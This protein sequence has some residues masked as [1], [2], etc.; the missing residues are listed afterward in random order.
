[1]E[2]ILRWKLYLSQNKQIVLRH[3]PKNFLCHIDS[4]SRLELPKYSSEICLSSADWISKLKKLAF[5]IDGSDIE[6]GILTLTDSEN[7]A[8]VI[9]TY[10]NKNPDND[11]ENKAIV[12]D[13]YLNKNPD[14]DS[15][16]K[17][18]VIDTYLNKNPDN[19]T[20]SD[21]YTNN[22]TANDTPLKNKEKAILN[23]TYLNN[24]VILN[25][26]YL[27]NEQKN[28][29]QHMYFDEQ[30][31]MTQEEL[32]DFEKAQYIMELTAPKLHSIELL[33]NYY[34]K[35]H[36]QDKQQG[37]Q[38]HTDTDI[39]YEQQES[40]N[41]LNFIKNN[42]GN[43]EPENNFP[44]KLEQF[45][46]KKL[47]KNELPF[48]NIP[49]SITHNELIEAQMS[50]QI[51]KLYYDYLKHNIL[52]N[53]K[54]I[55]YSIQFACENLDIINDIIMKI[56]QNHKTK[57]FRKQILVPKKLQPLVI[58][59]YHSQITASGGHLDFEH[60]LGTLY[61]SYYFKGAYSMMLSHVR[62]CKKCNLKKLAPSQFNT[63]YG[64][65]RIP[66][67]VGDA[68]VL[69]HIGPLIESNGYKY[70]LLVIEELSWYCIVFPCYTT[71]ALETSEHLVDLFLKY[72]GFPNVIY[73]DNATAFRN[74]IIEC[75]SKCLNIDIHYGIAFN[76]QSQSIAERFVQT[77]KK[78]ISFHCEKY[79]M[80]SNSL[81]FVQYCI[82]TTCCTKGQY[83]S[84]TLFHGRFARPLLCLDPENASS[85]MPINITQWPGLFFKRL[86]MSYNIARQFLLDKREKRITRHQM[87]EKIP[88]LQTGSIVYLNQRKIKENPPKGEQASRALRKEN[89]AGPFLILELQDH[90]AT[91]LDIYRLKA[92]PKNTA[93]KD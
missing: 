69:D 63:T 7:K 30:T 52:P 49:R 79:S 70:V 35:Y 15:E 77:V 74:S 61:N 82:N 8:I 57:T 39:N 42:L 85:H 64:Q 90:Q 33:N 59:F 11:S 78:L 31:N 50:D 73:M 81:S 45:V 44:E 76:P 21:I 87:K 29:V 86:I 16:N 26:T 14:N 92:L 89:N 93:E 88:S 51:L 27:N 43:I 4:L 28:I 65:K 40:I 58:E 24:E 56:T 55:A 66:T 6:D 41:T 47:L 46:E 54:S 75:L 1:M 67:F 23:D 83:N 18:I 71:T 19:N 22:N 25:D 20:I 13:T 80:W 48:N 72:T 36:L 17:A 34:G 32:K 91:L 84:W 12:I 2:R 10:L 37:I 38:L 9:D 68:L 60:S 53:K 62:A 3:L 5:Q